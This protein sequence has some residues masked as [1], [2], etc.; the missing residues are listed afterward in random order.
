LAAR[1][2][3]DSTLLR[4]LDEAPALLARGWELDWSALADGLV[5][6]QHLFVLGRGLGLG[7]AQEA[8]L[9]LKETCRLHA[10]AYSTAEVRHGPMA[11][12]ADGVPAL[13]FCQDDEARPGVEA[14]ARELAADGVRVYLAGGAVPGTTV[15]PALAA[16]AV[17]APMLFAQSLYR[18]AASAALARG[19]D[20]D[21]PARLQK[22]TRTT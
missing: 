21:H 12:F 19:L 13:V 4:A 7:L 2:A 6:A 3:G 8:A 14:L 5:P 10:E 15:L 16:P 22:V 11:L 20:P 9:K 18:C 17:I 1:W